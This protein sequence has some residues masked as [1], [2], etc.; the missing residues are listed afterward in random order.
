MLDCEIKFASCVEITDCF[1]RW[2]K[3]K[4]SGYATLCRLPSNLEFI[5]HAK[6]LSEPKR[7]TITNTH[8]ESQRAHPLTHQSPCLLQMIRYS[9]EKQKKYIHTKRSISPHST[10]HMEIRYFSP[11]MKLTTDTCNAILTQPALTCCKYVNR[12]LEL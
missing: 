7:I 4:S 11:S 10:G 2:T 1:Q 9:Q 5:I 6:H 3:T 8:C 12:Y